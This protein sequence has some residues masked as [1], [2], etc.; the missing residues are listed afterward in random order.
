MKKLKTATNYFCLPQEL[1]SFEL[2]Q[3]AVRTMLIW[4]CLTLSLW[5][6]SDFQSHFEF[7][8]IS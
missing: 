5:T 1:L 3:V 8:E 4:K 2:C 6:V 7:D